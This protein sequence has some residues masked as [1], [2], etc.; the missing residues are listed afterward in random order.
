MT[1]GRE[2]SMLRRT[3]CLG[4]P[5]PAAALLIIL[6]SCHRGDQIAPEGATI[7]LGATPT[8]IVKLDNPD[9]LVA[10]GVSR[11]GTADIL[12][13]ISSSVGVPLPDQDVRFTNSAGL[14][15]TGSLGNPQPASNI[16]IRTDSSGTAHVTLAASTTTTTVTAHS[17][18]AAGTLTLNA[19][20]GNI[21]SINLETDTTTC[22]GTTT[23]IT[24]CSQSLCL[25]VTVLDDKSMPLPNLT[26][27]FRLENNTSGTTTFKGTFDLAQPLTDSDGIARTT[28][29]PD[30][31]C[32]MQCGGLECNGIV[33][34]IIASLQGG[35]SPT[36]PL[37]LTLNIQ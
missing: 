30:S 31:S 11:C 22:P 4:L 20:D 16:P 18:K 7:D 2:K 34:Q 25:M 28:F 32:P 12:A 24:S 13:T 17:G 23:D 19:I 1:L 27:V 3:A 15:F 26:I 33:P 36:F 21:G 9:C 37:A 35:A 6:A 14:L 8:T 29:T 10:L 5:V